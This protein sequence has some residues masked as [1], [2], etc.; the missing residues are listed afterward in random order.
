MPKLHLAA[1]LPDGHRRPNAQTLA[2]NGSDVSLGDADSSPVGAAAVLLT[3]VSQARSAYP[4]FVGG[5]VSCRH[6][7]RADGCFILPFSTLAADGKD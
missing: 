4:Q 1:E 7:T 2:A 6:R 5:Q 3:P